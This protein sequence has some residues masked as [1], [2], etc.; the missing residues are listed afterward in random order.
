MKIVRASISDAKKI[1]II[2][3]NAYRDEKK[4]FGFWKNETEGPK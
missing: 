4:R 3:T 2:K 1:T